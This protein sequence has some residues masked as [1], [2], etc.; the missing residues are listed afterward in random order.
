[1]LFVRNV[2]GALGMLLKQLDEAVARN[3]AAD[4]RS[5][6]VVLTDDREATEAKLKELAREAKIS[7]QV[8]LVIPED[9]EALKPYKIHPDAEVTVVLYRKLNVLGNFAFKA[10][11]LKQQDIKAIV[12]AVAKIIPSQEE[13][14]KEAKA[15]LEAELKRKLEAELKAKLEAELE[16]KPEAAK[17]P[18]P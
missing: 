14:E 12:A 5:F 4:L 6:A 3:K 17:N 8:P 7:D 1:M 16:E 2:T 15:K 18:N 13:L 11:E 10:G 9:P